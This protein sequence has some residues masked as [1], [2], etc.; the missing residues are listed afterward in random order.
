MIHHDTILYPIGSLRLDNPS[1]L[2]NQDPVLMLCTHGAVFCFNDV[3]EKHSGQAV[4]ILCFCFEHVIILKQFK[5]V[6]SDYSKNCS[7]H[8]PHKTHKT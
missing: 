3:N 2:S 5:L 1:F 8:F 7:C 4:G 6:G